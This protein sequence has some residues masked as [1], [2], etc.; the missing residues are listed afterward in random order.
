MADEVA[1]FLNL[2]LLPPSP[3][4]PPWVHNFTYGPLWV[5]TSIQGPLSIMCAAVLHNTIQA[6]WM[7]A[8]E[9]QEHAPISQYGGSK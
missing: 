6:A 9:Q 1:C 2:L 7:H 4:P 8:G 3:P 5:C